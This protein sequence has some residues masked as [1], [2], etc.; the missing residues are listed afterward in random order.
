MATAMAL[1]GVL[2]D[3][4]SKSFEAYIDRL[5]AWELD[6]EPMPEMERLDL[7]DRC[8]ASLQWWH[9]HCFNLG[10]DTTQ[11]MI[12]D[13]RGVLLSELEQLGLFDEPSI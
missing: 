9:E 10:I 2:R 11:S 13:E 8:R 5:L 12:R 7:F 4:R 1:P 3:V 6:K